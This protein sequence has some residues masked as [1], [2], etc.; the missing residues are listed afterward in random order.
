MFP[1]SADH[2]QPYGGNHGALEPQEML[3]PLLAVRM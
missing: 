1:I 2:Q 3:V